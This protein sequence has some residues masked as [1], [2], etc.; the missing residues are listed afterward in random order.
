MSTDPTEP[1]HGVSLDVEDYRQ[2]LRRRWRG[3]AGPV[4]EGFLHDMNAACALLDETG[5]KATFFVTGTVAA[6]R[7]ELLRQWRDMGHEI[8]CHGWDHTPIWQMDRAAFGA[9]LER[10]AKSVED[11]CGS[12]VRGYRAAVFSIRSDTLWA[13]DALAER[14]FAYDS[15]IVPVRTR[16]Y[17]IDGFDRQPAVY[18][19]PGGGRIAELPLPVSHVLGRTMP[20]GGG[21]HFRLLSLES[22]LGAIRQHDG[23]DTAFVMY[24]HPDELGGRRFRAT[25]LVDGLPG[26]L[27]AKWLE[28]RSNRGRAGVPGIV[29][30]VLRR[31]RFTTLGHLADKTISDGTEKVLG[32]AR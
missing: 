14:G 19:L 15:S 24:V 31:F 8:A 25:D 10:A 23:D 22:I 21:G 20:V 17:G 5:T 3:E 2:I 7:P 27:R 32:K 9:D 26:K 13:L 28:I 12:P 11:A 4:T 16:R 1:L 30:E 29:R 18:R 6:S